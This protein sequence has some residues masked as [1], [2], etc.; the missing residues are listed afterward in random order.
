MTLVLRAQTVIPGGGKVWGIAV[1]GAGPD[2]T[3]AIASANGDADSIGIVNCTGI[4]G[5]SQTVK[6]PP[7][8]NP[9]AISALDIN[10]DGMTDF[11]VLN[12][13]TGSV[14][15]VLQGSSQD[16]MI[17]QLA[18]WKSYR[19]DGVPRPGRD[20]TP[21]RRAAW[22]GPGKSGMVR[23]LRMGRGEEFPIDAVASGNRDQP[24]C[25]SDS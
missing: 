6:M 25:R 20:R 23:H 16:A 17:S 15:V 7:G 13:G 24:R 10:R 18:S 3:V 19:D 1:A 22:S 2:G 12:Q 14:A 8:S 5:N 21:C 11:V 4:C 9:I